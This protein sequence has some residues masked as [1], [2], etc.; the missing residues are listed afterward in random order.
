[1]DVLFYPRINDGIDSSGRCS[2]YCTVTINQNR[3]VPFSTK[4]RILAKNWLP[5]KKTTN[6][7]FADIVRQELNRIENTLRRIK[8]D[9]EDQNQ[10]IT[11]EIVKHQYFKLK[12]EQSQKK[13]EKKET[14]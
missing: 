5:K 4:I 2:L 10:P 11:A 7:E 6:D 9:L 3:C 14:P 13:E 12:G 8:I 1:M